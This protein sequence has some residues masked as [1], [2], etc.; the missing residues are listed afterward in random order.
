[1]PLVPGFETTGLFGNMRWKLTRGEFV[2]LRCV[3][4]NDPNPQ[5]LEAG[6]SQCFA[7]FFSDWC[8]SQLG[9]GLGCKEL[10][11]FGSTRSL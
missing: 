7:L 9:T 8:S 6:G 3:A 11:P 1:M 10:F 5:G 2:P 4:Q